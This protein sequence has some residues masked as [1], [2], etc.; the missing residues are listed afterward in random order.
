MGERRVARSRS[1]R[2]S[3]YWYHYRR[4]LV[5]RAVSN[6]LRQ[7]RWSAERRRENNNQGAVGR[8]PARFSLSPPSLFSLCR[9]TPIAMCDHA[10]NHVNVWAC[11]SHGL[12]AS[13]RLG[14]RES[15]NI[16]VDTLLL[17]RQENSHISAREGGS[18]PQ[19]RVHRVQYRT[20]D[21]SCGRS[22]ELSGGG[23]QQRL[24]RVV[25]LET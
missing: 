17:L 25:T 4:I 8:R 23:R 19:Q 7:P 18:P 15:V 10:A 5:P 22:I 20:M 6:R 24:S 21:R 3:D 2:A 14:S 11:F 12:G 1:W 9:S 16:G 13:F